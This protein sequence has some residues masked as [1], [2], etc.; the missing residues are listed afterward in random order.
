MYIFQLLVCH[1]RGDLIGAETHLAAALELVPAALPPH[2]GAASW[3]AWTLGRIDLA[4]NRLQAGSLAVADSKDQFVKLVFPTFSVR[5]GIWLR[6]YE[7]IEQIAAQSVAST[8]KLQLPESIAVI[9]NA[10]MVMC[11]PSLVIRRK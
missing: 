9:S 4:R 11:E 2:L 8:E 1:L 5:L 6:E 7:R 3:N 10:G